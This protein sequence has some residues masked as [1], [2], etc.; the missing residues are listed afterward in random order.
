MPYSKSLQFFQKNRLQG[1]WKPTISGSQ[2]LGIS[3][4]LLDEVIHNPSWITSKVNANSLL[5]EVLDTTFTAL[6]N[7]P[8]GHRLS[9]PTL[10]ALIQLNLR[11]VAVS[12]QVLSKIKWG[13]GQE[14]TTILNKSLDLIFACVFQNHSVGDKTE[15]FLDLTDYIMNTAVSGHPN[16][17]GLILTQLILNAESGVIRNNGFE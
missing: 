2:L 9:F 7:V 16:A 6:E 3:E 17:K 11:T 8:E 10:E 5:S 13:S 1:K 4:N 14:E 15:L 12:Q